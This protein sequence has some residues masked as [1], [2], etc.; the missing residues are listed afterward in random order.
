MHLS[1]LFAVLATTAM[2]RVTLQSNAAESPD[3]AIAAYQR[4][5]YTTAYR[6][7]LPAAQAGD[8]N[9]QYLLGTQFWRGRDAVRN[10]VTLKPRSGLPAPPSRITA[11]RLPI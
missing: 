9:A 4:K 2:A 10:D 7:A 6:L 5:D 11:T 8:G 3:T 1:K